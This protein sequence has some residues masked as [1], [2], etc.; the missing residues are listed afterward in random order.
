[1]VMRSNIVGLCGL[2][3]LLSL[4]AHAGDLGDGCFKGM[5]VGQPLPAST[6]AILDEAVR[7]KGCEVS[8]QCGYVRYDCDAAVTLGG[9]LIEVTSL[10]TV[11]GRLVFYSLG[12]LDKKYTP[13]FARQGRYGQEGIGG[14]CNAGFVNFD[15]PGLTVA[16][17]SKFTRGATIKRVD[18]RTISVRETPGK[19]TTRWFLHVST[20]RLDD[21]VSASIARCKPKRS[22]LP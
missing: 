11:D 21:R 18:E 13:R 14:N 15:R 19:G 2:L 5:C 10:V 16:V 6:K 12:P 20:D 7:A 22:A 3:L 9:E 17:T 4:P 1:M 8:N